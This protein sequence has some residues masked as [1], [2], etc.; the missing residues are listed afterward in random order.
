[1]DSTSDGICSPHGSVDVDELVHLPVSITK[2]V[3]SCALPLPLAH[4]T[5][6]GQAGSDQ[7]EVRE[8]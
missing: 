8:S 5:C 3:R 7:Q 4:Q 6:L 2:R 1:M